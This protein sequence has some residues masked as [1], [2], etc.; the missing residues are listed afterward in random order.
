MQMRFCFAEHG[1]PQLLHTMFFFA[2]FAFGPRFR[3]RW[4]D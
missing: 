3:P 4:P 1:F 2:R